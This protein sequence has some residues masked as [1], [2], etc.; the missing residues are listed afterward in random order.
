MNPKTPP[1][2]DIWQPFDE[3]D[4]PAG[5]LWFLPG[6]PDT[7]EEAPPPPDPVQPDSD[8]LTQWQQAEAQSAAR[9]AKVATRLG[10]LDERLARGPQGWRQR[11]ALLEAADLSWHSGDRLGADRLALWV[12]LR[13]SGAQDD[14]AALARAGWAVRRLTGGPAPL[15]DLAA[16][17][18]RRDTDIDDDERIT[19]RADTWAEAVQTAQSLHPIS[20]ACMGFHLWSLAGMGQHGAMMEAA[21]TAARI[22]TTDLRGAIFAPLAMG[23]NAGLRATGTP[24]ERL[25]RWLATMEQALLAAT[26]HL[27]DI[28]AWAA[29]AEAVMRPLSGRTPP[30]LLRA[31][32]EWPLLSAPMAEKLTGS[33]R[34]AVQRN[35]AWMQAHGLIREVTGQGRFR[36][37]RA[38]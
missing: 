21:V 38:A 36:M 12:G 30:A 7:A 11:L 1:E 34:A 33:S 14:A 10:G 18:D 35:L 6:P 27:D 5:D 22:A 16:F 4:G 37:W 20:R 29:K 26:R 24:H 19:D 8:L 32:T 2:D 31:L 3:F 13:L 25:A 15:D 28:E 23:G 17:L 9:L